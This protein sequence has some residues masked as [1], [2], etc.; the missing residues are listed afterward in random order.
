MPI[1]WPHL[2]QVQPGPT[3]GPSPRQRRRPDWSSACWR[4][5]LNFI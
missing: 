2:G 1:R 3:P 5:R 4:Q